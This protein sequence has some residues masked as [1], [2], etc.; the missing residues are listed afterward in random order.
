MCESETTPT[1][2]KDMPC[3]ALLLATLVEE[4]NRQKVVDRLSKLDQALFYEDIDKFGLARIEAPVAINQAHKVIRHTMSKYT[5][6]R[7]LVGNG[8]KRFE[9]SKLRVQFA[10]VLFEARD[11]RTPCR[12]AAL[13]PAYSLGEVEANVKHY[14]G[15]SEFKFASVPSK[16]IV[17]GYGLK[18][19]KSCISCHKDSKEGELLGYLVYAAALKK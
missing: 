14:F 9:P 3:L 1:R 4:D 10:P 19:N 16:W 7:F 13:K 17:S 5:L 2:I 12:I 8:T 6:E 11:R 15:K 18:A